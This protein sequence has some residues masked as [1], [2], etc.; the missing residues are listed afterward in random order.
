MR[1]YFLMAAAAFTALIFSVSCSKD[2][3]GDQTPSTPEN[4]DIAG[5]YSGT[6]SVSVSDSD[7]PTTQP[8]NITVSWSENSTDEID[9]SVADFAFGGAKLGSIDLKSIPVTVDGDTY[10][11][12]TDGA[13]SV[14]VGEGESS[15]TCTIVAL[16]TVTDGT[17]NLTLDI[18]AVLV[19]T[20]INVDATFTGSKV[21]AE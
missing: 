5:N 18:T 12:A 2:D 11:F 21:V 14:T 10:T 7:T 4:T 13:Q 6:L 9:L 19:I 8:Q 15:M 3:S 1:R 20:E 16:G 17:M